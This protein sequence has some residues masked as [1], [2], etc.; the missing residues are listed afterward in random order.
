MALFSATMPKPILDITQTY[1]KKDAKYIRVTPKEITIDLVKQAYYRVQR[2]DKNEV[3][4]RLMDYYQPQRTLIFCNTKRMVDSLNEEL[5][6]RG[7]QA[8]GLHGDLTQH[9]R[10]N[11]MN[12]FRTGKCQILIATDV[13]ARGLD[14]SG[15][16]A[17][18]NY[19]VPE[20]IEYYVHRIGRTGRA[21]RKGRSF[22]LVCGREIFKIRDIER[23]CHTKI[24]ERSIP[25]AA[26]I[27][28]VKAEA[29]FV[30]AKRVMDEQNLDDVIA[31]ISKA[32]EQYEFTAIELAAAFIKT[33]LGDELAEIKD[34]KPFFKP[35]RGRQS[36]RRQRT[37][38]R[39]Y[40]ARRA[41]YGERKSESQRGSY[42]K[43]PGK[44][45]GRPA[46]KP[47]GK[48]PEKF[49]GKSSGKPSS[50]RKNSYYS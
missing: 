8:E 1:Q 37:G 11:V 32:M 42:G 24:K 7:Y 22:T 5:K 47:G 34:E 2:K 10:D 29:I 41:P 4:C 48:P 44:T 25:K 28:R 43:S 49:S 20:D 35:D 23:F 12:L 15:V 38:A 3:L 16:D 19:D 9:Q 31:R 6:G 27:T 36:D 13:A 18:F 17:V 45:F 33:K 21:G 30:E 26:D 40:D 46:G 39:P 50:S 14:I